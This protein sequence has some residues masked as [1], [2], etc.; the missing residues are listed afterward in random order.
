MAL[1]TGGCHYSNGCDRYTSGCGN[2]PG[3]RSNSDSDLTTRNIA[4]KNRYL[5][6]D[7]FVTLSNIWLSGHLKKSFLFSEIKD[8]Y[9]NIPIN[10]N[11]FTLS[12]LGLARKRLD[13]PF[14][15]KVIFFGAAYVTEE[16]KGLRFLLRALKALH[17]ELSEEERTSYLLLIAGNLT[18]DVVSELTFEAKILGHL[19]H[20][21]LPWA[22]QASDIFVSPSIQDAGPMMVIQSLLCG[23]PVVTFSM[24]NA[25][26]FVENGVTGYKVPVGDVTGLKDGIKSILNMPISDR[27]FMRDSCRSVAMKKSSLEAFSKRFVEIYDAV[28]S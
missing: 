6:V 3:L 4:F 9:L 14:E 27:I 18:E 2:C 12:D 17:D 13:I 11:Q 16:R 22:Y 19:S 8:F 5:D 26:D 20:E 1:F 25:F 15:K 7:R 28:E 23:I 24:G 10:E 21:R